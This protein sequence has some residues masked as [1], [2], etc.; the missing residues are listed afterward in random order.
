MLATIREI[1]FHYTPIPNKYRQEPPTQ[2]DLHQNHV[3]K[4]TAP[5]NFLKTL[6]KLG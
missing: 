1:S 4:I 3:H 6:G 5:P 2:N